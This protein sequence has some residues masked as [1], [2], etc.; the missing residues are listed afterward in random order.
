MVK[1]EYATIKNLLKIRFKTGAK[2]FM[3]FAIAIAFL[4]VWSL[5][6][7]V[8]GITRSETIRFHN[9]NDYSVMFLASMA[10]M[11]AIQMFMYKTTND[12]LSVY[13]QTNTSRFVSS[14]LYSFA[15]VAIFA[16]TVLIIYLIQYG[17]FLL[18]FTFSS[19]MYFSLNFSM[20]LLIVGVFV[21]L[22]YG[23][24]IV[25]AIELLGVVLRK[26]TYYAFVALAAVLTLIVVNLN[27]FIEGIPNA[28]AFLINESS[29]VLFFMKAIGLLF[30]IIAVAFV[31]NKN[32]V[33]HK[34]QGR[35][36]NK[37]ILLGCI[38]LAVILIIT[39]FLIFN[40]A[41]QQGAVSWIVEGNITPVEDF[42]DG[43]EEI[44]IDISHLPNDSNIELNIDNQPIT[45]EI[46]RSSTF[47][48]GTFVF[49]SGTEY[50]R[51][52]QGDNLNIWYRLPLFH[53]DGAML[54]EFINPQM[55]IY[56]EENVLTIS[57]TYDKVQVVILPIW[58]FARQF[59]VFEGRGLFTDRA[60]GFH[61]GGG[62]TVNIYFSVD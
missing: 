41:T 16:F 61:A 10:L 6:S 29:L 2:G 12:R 33:Y 4:L 51:N 44:H 20:G 3:W 43:F 18:V 57:Y 38:A 15:L 52:I 62:M 14:L 34:S 1:D 59:T 58:S 46:G 23:L 36:L 48:N 9:I 22:A 35:I 32:T 37:G 42:F 11:L 39:P 54:Y 5:S 26:W 28:L 21:Y 19:N 13:P 53:F 17:V 40:T 45:I 27:A 47:Y 30:V 31:I 8:L 60:V 55:S 25:A 7:T 24:L 50:L 49:L 56:L